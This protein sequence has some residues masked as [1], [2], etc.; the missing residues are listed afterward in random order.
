MGRTRIHAERILSILK[1]HG[2]GSFAEIRNWYKE[3]YP[4][5]ISTFS[6]NENLLWLRDRKL[7]QRKEYPKAGK[8]KGDIVYAITEEY[9]TRELR[10]A[11]IT[12]L[13]E[14]KPIKWMP[15]KEPTFIL[16]SEGKSVDVLDDDLIFGESADCLSATTLRR[17]RL[18]IEKTVRR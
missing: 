7:V 16:G 11:L 13:E 9:L 17:F 2:E 3:D 6:L 10:S 5:E 4:R 12:A 18:E 8:L 15:W 14:I 1:K